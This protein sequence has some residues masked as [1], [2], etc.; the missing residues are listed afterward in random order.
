M[1]QESRLTPEQIVQSF[2]ETFPNN[3]RDSR[4]ERHTAGLKKTE[5][6]HIWM[7]M[8]REKF[9]DILKHIMTIDKAPHLAVV[10]GYDSNETI[11]LIYHFSVYHGTPYQ[12]LSLN[13]VVSLPKADPTI[14]TITD[15]YPGAL[16]TEQ[17]KQEMLGVVVK[18]IPV[19]R[20]VFISDDF[21]KGVYPWRRDE[22]G[23]AKMVKNLHHEVKP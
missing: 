20:R 13:F 12:E 3:I 6:V 2:Q 9:K 16:I 23:P 19:N 5:L 22:T 10:S 14:E 15:V 21:P 18:G 4:I 7:R 1:S 8:D 11:E 17:E